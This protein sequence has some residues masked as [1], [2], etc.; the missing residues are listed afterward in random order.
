MLVERLRYTDG[1]FRLS[2]VGS[3]SLSQFQTA[4]DL[5]NI[6]EIIRQ[7]SPVGWTDLFLQPRH[8]VS[9]RVENTSV[10]SLSLDSLLRSSAV[11]EQPFENHLRIDFHRKG[12][13]WCFPG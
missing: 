10:L 3:S 9:D 11:A 4:L 8:I 6:V 7:S 13:R 5:P 2:R 1:R 12:L